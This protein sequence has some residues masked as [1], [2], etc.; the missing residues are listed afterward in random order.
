MA[1]SNASWFMLL[2]S[3]P[4][5]IQIGILSQ[6]SGCTKSEIISDGVS[7]GLFISERYSGFFA[8]LSN[9]SIPDVSLG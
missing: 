7:K 4:S 9:P 3:K 2:F 1:V 6:V 5:T 8:T